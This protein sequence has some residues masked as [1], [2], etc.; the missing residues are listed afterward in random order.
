MRRLL[1]RADDLGSFSGVTPAVLHARRHG[2]VRNASIMV[3]TPWFPATAAALRER[4]DLCFGVHLT[5][6]GEWAHHPWRPVL[7]AERVPC[8]VDEAGFLLRDPSRIHAR[9]VQA[10]QILA[11]CTAQLARARAYGLDIRYVDTHMGW[12]WIHGRDGVRLAAMLPEWCQRHGVGWANG[13][14]LDR[15]P[16]TPGA[17]GRS[18]LL[19]ALDQVG[20]G[21]WLIITHP[22]WPSAT[23]AGCDLDQGTAWVQQERGAD[24]AFLADATLAEELTRRGVTLTRYDEVL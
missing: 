19:Q 23:L 14:A 8:L 12:E 16:S 20:A 22:C 5:I 24:A 21:T 3:P 4:T 13:V 11:E 1:V 15:L 18:R 7:P 9:D 2:V 17:D 6:C 10:D